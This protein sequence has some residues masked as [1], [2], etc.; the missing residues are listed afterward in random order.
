MEKIEQ[1]NEKKTPGRKKVSIDSSKSRGGRHL[2]DAPA[3]YFFGKD[4]LNAELDEVGEPKTRNKS[5]QVKNIDQDKDPRT[6][7]INLGTVRQ[8]LHSRRQGNNDPVTIEPGDLFVGEHYREIDEFFLQNPD[9]RWC[10]PFDCR[11]T[12]GKFIQHPRGYVTCVGNIID[13]E[14]RSNKKAATT[15]K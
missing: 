15:S 10:Q 5:R 9:H 1:K 13:E 14:R 8:V 12:A 11:Q 2:G 4:Y 6:L 3:E 7:F